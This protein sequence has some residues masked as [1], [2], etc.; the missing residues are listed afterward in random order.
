MLSVCLLLVVSLGMCSGTY[1]FM[2]GGGV[3]GVGRVGGMGGVGGISGYRGYGFDDD[4]GYRFGGMSRIGMGRQG[5]GMSKG[6][7]MGGN[8]GGFPS[9]QSGSMGF[10]RFPPMGGAIGGMSGPGGNAFG[11]FGRGPLGGSA[12]FVGGRRFP[13]YPG[14][15]RR[16]PKGK[17]RFGN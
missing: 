12:G 17:G 6:Y 16:Y 7:G 15:N 3:G 4:E 2:Y 13:G 11:G 8:M 14:G 1:N 5:Y 10:G 9:V